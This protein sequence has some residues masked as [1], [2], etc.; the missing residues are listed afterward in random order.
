MAIKITAI[1]CEGPHDVAFTTK[2]LRTIGFVN[3]ERLKLGDYPQPISGLLVNAATKANV[4]DFNLQELRQALLPMNTMQNADH[5]LFLYSLGGDSKIV[6][7]TLLVRDF[8]SFIP[9]A[10]EISALPPDTVL[11]IVFFFDADQ[12]G[13]ADRLNYINNELLPITGIRPFTGNGQ[14]V[15]ASGLRLGCYIFTG[16]DNNTGNLEE[17]LLPILR[18]GNDQIFDEAEVYLQ[19]N[20]SVYRGNTRDYSQTKS[21]IGIAGQLQKSG[22]TNTVIIGQTDYLTSAKIAGHVKCTEIIDFFLTI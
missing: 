2:I 6:P 14:I 19:R 7:R 3:N 21:L 12:H 10:G 9:K 16:P 15:N 20:Y 4:Q 11:T 5:F 22:S 1:L 18:D 17:I 8:F 13:T